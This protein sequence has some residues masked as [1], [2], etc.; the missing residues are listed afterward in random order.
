MPNLA[1]YSIS[2]LTLSYLTLKEFGGFCVSQKLFFGDFSVI[3]GDGRHP[4]NFVGLKFDSVVVED[5]NVFL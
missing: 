3:I 2:C 1:Q 5:V 4:F